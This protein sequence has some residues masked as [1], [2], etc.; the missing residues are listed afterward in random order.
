MGLGE[1]VRFLGQRTDVSELLEAAD[2][3]CQPNQTPDSFG[4]SFIEA[5]WAG[6]PVVTSA[7]GGA[8]EIVDE[9]C[10]FLVQPGDAAGL[11]ACLGPLIEQQELR[12]RLGLHGPARAL[13]L[14]NPAQQ[15]NLLVE[16]S[17]G[18][19]RAAAVSP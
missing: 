8:L 14:C 7:L 1:R 2:I 18:G 19:L 12:S 4:I 5:L 11:A 6:R 10:G 15:M 9:S 16:M 3:F 17:R 13:E